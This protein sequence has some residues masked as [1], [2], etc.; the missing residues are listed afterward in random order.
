MVS[1]IRHVT[2]WPGL[3]VW[4]ALIATATIVISYWETCRSYITCHIEQNVTSTN[5]MD[6]IIWNN[7]K[8]NNKYTPFSAGCK[9]T[10]P[11]EFS[12]HES[13]PVTGFF[14][15]IEESCLWRNPWSGNEV[16]SWKG[17][18]CGS[19]EAA[20]KVQLKSKSELLYVWLTKTAL[21]T[22]NKLLLTT[23][24]GFLRIGMSRL[25]FWSRWR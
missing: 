18:A 25:S 6:S 1:L 22:L 14:S 5:T 12:F 2:S 17:V 3:G 9:L 21:T 20:N 15:T 8:L 7:I 4:S 23:F 13:T 19:A 11:A 24:W 16:D 10:G